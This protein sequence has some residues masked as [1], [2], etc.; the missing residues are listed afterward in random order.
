MSEAVVV[1]LITGAC[2]IIAQ[3]VISRSSAKELFAKLDKQSKVSDEKIKSR[4]DVLQADLRTLSN[5]VDAHNKVVERTFQ[6][7]RRADVAEE[8]IKVAN[9]RLDEL[10]RSAKND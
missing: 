7:E 2:A 10:D 9:H 1:A 6:L 5:R 3:L 4:I 8:K